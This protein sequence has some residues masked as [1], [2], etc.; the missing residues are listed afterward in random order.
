MNKFEFCILSPSKCGTTFLNNIFKGVEVF[1]IFN[2]QSSFCAN[3]LLDETL[4]LKLLKP[5]KI[6]IA[7]RNLNSQFDY[8]QIL[9]EYNKKL[10]FIIL[11]RNP[12]TRFLSNLRHHIIKSIYTRKNINPSIEETKSLLE[13]KYDFNKFIEINGVTFNSSPSF[14]K[15]SFYFQMLKNYLN[16]FSLDNFLFIQS[17]LLFSDPGLCMKK[18]SSFLDV[19]NNLFLNLD[20]NSIFSNSSSDMSFNLYKKFIFRKINILQLSSNVYSLCNSSFR[21]DIY[22]LEKKV[23]YKISSDWFE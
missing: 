17:E 3:N 14:L 12:T 19:D 2:F 23:G 1:N 16:L 9:F 22:L 11:L 5:E 8:S 21:D 20:F 4:I 10:K 13:S 18:I 15:K 6:N 7:R